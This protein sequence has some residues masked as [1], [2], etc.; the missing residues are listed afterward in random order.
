M[1]KTAFRQPTAR[2][3]TAEAENWVT[4]SPQSEPAPR[5]KPVPVEKAA[6]LTIDLPP[7]LHASFKAACAKQRTRMVDEVRQF[8]ED[9]T[10][11]HV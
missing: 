6:R 1:K 2:P 7:D 11:K 3:L 4:E 5:Q 9:W 10:Q 8:I